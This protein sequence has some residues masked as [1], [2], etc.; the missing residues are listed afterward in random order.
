MLARVIWIDS[1]NPEFI[2]VQFDTECTAKIE[3][4]GAEVNINDILEGNFTNSGGE[5]IFNK[6]QNQDIDV[7]IQDFD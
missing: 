6:T 1:K 2:K 3:L 5:K 4:L 7:Y